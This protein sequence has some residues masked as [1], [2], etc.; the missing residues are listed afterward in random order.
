MDD[1][2]ENENDA[3]FCYNSL[4]FSKLIGL[5]FILNLGRKGEES[6]VSEVTIDA[7]AVLKI[8]KH[9]HDSLP[10]MV[11]GSLLG[12]DTNNRLEITYSY[13]FPQPK[14]DLEKVYIAIQLTVK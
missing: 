1:D 12:L 5:Q 10:T 14:T 9:C 3:R 2:D 11:A 8:V 4:P 13:P 7:V 6:T